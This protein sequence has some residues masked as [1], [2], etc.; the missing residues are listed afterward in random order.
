[1]RRRFGKI[2]ADLADQDPLIYVVVGDIGYRVF[3]E[4]RTRHP[5][6]FINM[7]VCEQSMIGVSAGMALE[8]L[9][10]WVY[11]ITPFLIERPFEQIKLDIDQQNV[12]VKLVGYADYP[13]LGP[14]HAEI[15][16][17]HLM[18][19]FKTIRSFFPKNGD[20]T[21]AFIKQAYFMNSPAFISLKSDPFLDRS[22]TKS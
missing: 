22:I 9:K 12:N 10:P 8:G 3:D 16:A 18:K 7:G 20:E 15:D 5:D 14:T 21:E 19:L 13:T 4:F 11:T 1:M 17:I 2:I 6:R